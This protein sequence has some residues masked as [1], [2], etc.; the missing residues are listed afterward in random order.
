MALLKKEI[1]SLFDSP[2]AYILLIV[3]LVVNN[4]FF[5]RSLTV[6]NLATL[7]PMFDF[8]PWLFLFLLP[9]LT[10]RLL[11]EERKEGTVDLLLSQPQPIYGVVL[12]KFLAVL[13]FVITAL[14]FTLPLPLLLS[15]AGSFDWGQIAGQYLSALLLAMAMAA[16][17]LFASALSKNQVVAYIIAVF[18]LFIFILSGLEIVTVAALGNIRAL[19]E[20]LS[21]LTHYNNLNRGILS[22]ADVAYFMG[23]S[24]VFIVGSYWLVVR[25]RWG[26]SRQ[27]WKRDQVVMIALFLFFVISIIGSGLLPGRLDLTSGRFY[28]LAEGTRQILSDL[29]EVITIKFFYSDTLPSQFSLMKKE[30]VDLLSD[31]QQVSSN[32]IKVELVE[33]KP[34]DSEQAS[35]ARSLGIAP[36]QF[37]ILRKQEFSLQ[38]GFFGLAVIADDQSDSIPFVDSLNNLEYKIVSLIYKL[39]VDNKP[40]VAFLAGHGERGGAGE[41]GTFKQLLSNQFNLEDI[42]WS[43]Q[44]EGDKKIPSE[45]KVIIIVNPTSAIPVDELQKLHDFIKGGGS[46]FLLS[47]GVNVAPQLLQAT[48]NNSNINDFLRVYGVEVNQ[49]LVFDLQ[50]NESVSFGGGII[51]YILPYPFWLRAQLAPTAPW[52]KITSVTLPWASSLSLNSTS[53]QVEVKPLLLTSNLA[54]KKYTPFDISPQVKFPSDNLSQQVVAATIKVFNEDRVGR[55]VVVG[56]ADFISENFVRQRGGN[57]NLT[58]ALQAVEWLSQDQRLATIR[59][60]NKDPEPLIFQSENQP[61]FI[62]WFNLVGVPLLIVILAGVRWWYRRFYFKRYVSQLGNDIGN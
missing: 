38:Q 12:S 48:V 58:F 23:V 21:F 7:R 27:W 11:A 46:I 50:A 33:I 31:L 54:G 42:I 14:L 60:K 24:L 6:S 57:D 9:G 43:T 8:L 2:I 5:W 44:A 35:T 28:T 17:G 41:L 36:V 47:D 19:L 59:A 55:L 3:F 16:V 29:D 26:K 15:Q 34:T 40:Q 13:F 10:M 51:S 56:D 22:V 25:T 1:K 39:T 61:N 52:Q 37:N 32:N 45:V 53:T 18:V 30:V 62:K 49:D 20:N 4:F